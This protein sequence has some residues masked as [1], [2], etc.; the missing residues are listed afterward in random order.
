MWALASE[1]LKPSVVGA[2]PRV[3]ATHY[4][5]DLGWTWMNINKQ[6]WGEDD[7]EGRGVRFRIRGH[8]W[9][10]E[11]QRADVRDADKGRLITATSVIS[12]LTSISWKHSNENRKDV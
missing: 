6:R 12:P 8:G 11:A 10:N 5:K 3:P 2:Q 7:A 1:A 4:A 9:G